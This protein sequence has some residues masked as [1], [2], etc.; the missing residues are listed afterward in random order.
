MKYHRTKLLGLL[1]V[2]SFLLGIPAA[3]AI[4]ESYDMG[5]TE[6]FYS[7]VIDKEFHNGRIAFTFQANAS[8]T[9]YI[10]WHH[11]NGSYLTIW[12]VIGTSGNVNMAVDPNTNYYYT[13]SK[14]DGYAVHIDFT[15]EGKPSGIPG[16]EII[17]GLLA[18][19]GIVGL[20]S[21][22]KLVSP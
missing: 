19:V 8:L 21:R 9:V 15:L 12:Q 16:F 20:L 13:F 18:L 6:V 5:S 14:I 7:H 22:K 10:E 3:V 17:I 2:L 11:T 4:S 1:L